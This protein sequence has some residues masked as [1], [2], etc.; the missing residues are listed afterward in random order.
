MNK[1]SFLV[2][3]FLSLLLLAA[4]EQPAEKTN[5]AP[6]GAP[7]LMIVAMGDSLSAG[8]GVAEEDAYPARLETKLRAAGYPV[9]VVNGGVSGETSS[10]ALSRLDWLLTLKPAIVILETGGND[11]LRGIP[12]ALVEKNIEAIVERLQAE[13]VVVV[14]AGMKMFRNMGAEYTQAFE[15][16]YPAVAQRRA[17]IFMPFFLR[18]V[19]GVPNRMQADALHPNAAGYRIVVETL[20]PYVLQALKQVEEGKKGQAGKS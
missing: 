13:G 7:A 14:L 11:G 18:E 6:P 19:V 4:C 16:L 12:P 17:V 2:G 10:G 3:G 5:P 15:T 20:Y 9:Q 1:I 8:F